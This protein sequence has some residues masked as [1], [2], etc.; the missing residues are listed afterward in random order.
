MAK[1]RRGV[2]LSSEQLVPGSSID[3][4]G[5]FVDPKVIIVHSGF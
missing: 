4:I 2:R 1:K 5:V 3:G